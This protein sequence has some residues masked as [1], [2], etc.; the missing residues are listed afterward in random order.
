MLSVLFLLTFIFA[1]GTVFGQQPASERPVSFGRDVLAVLTKHGC[2]SSGC[3]GGVKGKGGFKLSLDGLDPRE[4]YKWI[5]KGG[6][7]Q[8]LSPEVLPPVRSRV[9]LQE[10]EK[11]LLLLK[12]TMTVAHGGGE[13]FKPDSSAYATILEW[14]R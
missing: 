13:R 1:S 3:H 9:D 8:V 4:D 12:P 14:V 10:P 11:S 7:Y 5:V 2:N 6:T